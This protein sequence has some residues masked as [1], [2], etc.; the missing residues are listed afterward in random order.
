MKLD[1]CKAEDPNPLT[2]TIPTTF[3]TPKLTFEASFFAE[4]ITV[5]PHVNHVHRP[6]TDIL[7]R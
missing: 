4:E 2:A 5:H 3:S 7:G 6:K 1:E